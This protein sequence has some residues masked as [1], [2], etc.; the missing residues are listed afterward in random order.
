M[1]RSAVNVKAQRRPS[2][3][4]PT[5]VMRPVACLRVRTVL[6]EHAQR[7][8]APTPHC[9]V[10]GRVALFIVR[11]RISAALQQR[12]HALSIARTRGRAEGRAFLCHFQCRIV[13][14]GQ[15][16]RAACTRN[17]E[18]LLECGKLALRL[19]LQS[20][21]VGV[22]GRW[23]RTGRDDDKRIAQT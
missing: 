14:E 3:L 22:G 5:P 4:P 7:F 17:A 1:Q 13:R 18:A 11:V 12:Q 15:R 19:R 10:Q 8:D 16:V 21:R 6:E 23:R 9:R 2:R 20:L